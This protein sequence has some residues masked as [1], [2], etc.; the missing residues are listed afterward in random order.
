MAIINPKWNLNNYGPRGLPIQESRE[1]VHT[2]EHDQGV[3]CFI[4]ANTS[5]SFTNKRYQV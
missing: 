3:L 2:P 5:S 4:P 1:L